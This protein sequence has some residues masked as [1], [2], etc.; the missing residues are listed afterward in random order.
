MVSISPSQ[1]ER[2]YSAAD[3]PGCWI[4]LTAPRAAEGVMQNVACAPDSLSEIWPAGF[5][6]GIRVCLSRVGGRH[7]RCRAQP[8]QMQAPL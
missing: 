1:Y 5:R 2:S 3:T 8:K 7:S 6:S 4:Q